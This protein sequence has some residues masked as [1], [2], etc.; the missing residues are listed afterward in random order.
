MEQAYVSTVEVEAQDSCALRK[1]DPQINPGTIAAQEDF[2]PILRRDLMAA[3]NTVARDLGLRASSVVVLDALLSCLP[4][5][6]EKTGRDT[7]ISNRVL[8][9]VFASNNTLCFRAK[10]LTDRQLRRHLERL[11]QVGLI[12]R[13]DSANGKR[14]PIYRNGEIFGAFGIDLSPLLYQSR[15]LIDL[16]QKARETAAELKGIKSRIQKL[17]GICQNL[18]LDEKTRTF[19]DNIGKALRRV[20]TTVEQAGEMLAALVKVVDRNKRQQ[21]SVDNRHALPQVPNPKTNKTP[22]SDGQNVRHK[23]SKKTDTKKQDL[24]C[25]KAPDWSTLNNITDFFPNAPC[26]E[27]MLHRIIYDFGKM[28]GIN[29]NLLATSIARLGAVRTVSVLNSTASRLRS[30]DNITA[31]YTKIIG[32]A[33]PSKVGHGQQLPECW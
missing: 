13:R 4:C 14:F 11:E 7:P 32:S 30:I 29:H 15:H 28:L 24:E 33:L 22:A 6:D 20:G 27:H 16:A 9:T 23:E 12:R 17:C 5:R 25:V 21:Q 18:S 8:L 1:D 19:V 31:Y 3:V 10:G 26:N 2:D